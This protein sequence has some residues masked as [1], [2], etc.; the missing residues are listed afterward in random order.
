MAPGLTIVSNIY[1]VYS[2]D[3]EGW[4]LGMDGYMSQGEQQEAHKYG[5]ECIQMP[6]V[7]YAVILLQW[8]LQ[9]Q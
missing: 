8:F 6:V 1:R 7:I 4:C 5:T 9:Q 2:Q 3:S